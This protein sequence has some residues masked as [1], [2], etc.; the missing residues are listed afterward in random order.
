M[1]GDEDRSELVDGVTNLIPTDQR[2]RQIQVPKYNR[3]LPSSSR[4]MGMKNGKNILI[5]ME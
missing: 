2:T 3:H 1:L 5:K 4:S